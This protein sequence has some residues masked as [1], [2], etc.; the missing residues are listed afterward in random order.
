[1]RQDL[2]FAEEAGE[3]DRALGEAEDAR[4]PPVQARDH[5]RSRQELKVSAGLR[6]EPR[7]EPILRAAKKR[8]RDEYQQ[9]QNDRG[10][11]N[12]GRDRDPLTRGTP[13]RSQK[14]TIGK[15]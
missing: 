1:M 3:G 10:R 15:P 11:E 12:R 5:L 9:G 13:G 8:A 6:Q 2:G 4:D 7:R 14:T